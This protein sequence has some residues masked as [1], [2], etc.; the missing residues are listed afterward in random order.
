MTKIHIPVTNIS[1]VDIML[2]PR[3][4]LGRV[5]QVRSIYPADAKPTKVKSGLNDIEEDVVATGVV[6]AEGKDMISCEVKD[7]NKSDNT[8]QD[9]NR[10]L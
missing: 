6:V 4:V 10:K 7:L 5:Q 2:A 9:T 1:N 3:T 8:G